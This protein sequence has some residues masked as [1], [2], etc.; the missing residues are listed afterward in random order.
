MLNAWHL[1]GAANA[2]LPGAKFDVAV[3]SLALAT[4]A[5]ACLR[6]ARM[7]A[8]AKRVST[9]L[10]H[11]GTKANDFM[12]LN[13]PGI[14]MSYNQVIHDLVE[15]G[16]YHDSKVFLWK[17]SS[18]C[19]W[20]RLSTVC[21]QR[22]TQQPIVFLHREAN[23]CFI[24]SGC[25]GSLSFF[26]PGCRPCFSGL[27]AWLL[28]TLS[29]AWLTEEK[30]ETACSLNQQVKAGKSLNVFSRQ[31]GRLSSFIHNMYKS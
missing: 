21:C 4:S 16:K 18:T 23:A 27:A 2:H 3:T 7:S 13:R 11:S 24:G 22:Y 9:V 31:V 10:L 17:K 15:A 19:Q 20:F 1:T 30:R 26:F 29:C 25:A 8:F 5:I 28:D 12:R 14:C 6:N